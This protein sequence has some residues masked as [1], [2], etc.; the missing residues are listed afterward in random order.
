MRSPRLVPTDAWREAFP[1]AVAA[2]VAIHGLENPATTGDLDRAKRSLEVD[3]RERWLGKTRAGVRAE[4]VLAA[5]DRYYKRFGQNYH[6]AMQI[7]SIA[8]KNKA[9]PSRA[10]IVESMFMAELESGVLAAVH[11]LDLVSGDVILDVTTGEERY[12]RY[13]GVAEACKAGDM[14]MR[15]DV[16]VLTS[17]IQGP[18]TLARV[19]PQTTSAIFCLYAPAGVGM[20]GVTNCLDA[21]VRFAS[22]ITTS[23]TASPPSIVHG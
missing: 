9:I 15:D 11:D 18:T 19:S 21:I 4:P 22:L 2:L 6:V 20:A 17:V 7:E 5:Y 23:A 3:L 8:L 12:T 13:D 14:A 1:G 10:A 16:G